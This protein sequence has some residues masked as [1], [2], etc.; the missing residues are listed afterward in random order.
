MTAWVGVVAGDGEVVRLE[1]ITIQCRHSIMT[2]QARIPDGPGGRA[3]LVTRKDC[4]RS[5]H[6][7]ES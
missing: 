4:W 1:I 7:A 5:D 3:G 6:R 2:A